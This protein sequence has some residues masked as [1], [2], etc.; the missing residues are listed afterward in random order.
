M[1]IVYYAVFA[2]LIAFV[3][4]AVFYGIFQ[5]RKSQ[6]H[7]KENRE[8]RKQIEHLEA[9]VERLKNRRLT[10]SGGLPREVKQELEDILGKMSMMDDPLDEVMTRF[11]DLK[12]DIQ[13]LMKRR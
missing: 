3:V 6:K 9:T 5:A 7:N 1:N 12:R 11:E 2:L 10:A 13:N 8:L 4:I